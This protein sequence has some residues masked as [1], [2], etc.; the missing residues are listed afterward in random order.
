M[1]QR[2]RQHFEGVFAQ[3]LF[4][5]GKGAQFAAKLAD[6][7][8]VNDVAAVAGRGGGGGG[9]RVDGIL[10]FLRQMSHQQ[11]VGVIV[12]VKKVQ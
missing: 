12:F 5:E 11:S 1:D 2:K 9:G 6:A 7:V 4:R 10:D 3:L 8:A